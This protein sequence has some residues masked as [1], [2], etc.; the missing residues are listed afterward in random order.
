MRFRLFMVLALAPLVGCLRPGLEVRQEL[1]LYELSGARLLKCEVV[2]GPQGAQEGRGGRR[3]ERS[4]SR[5]QLR[6]VGPDGERFQGEWM[7]VRQ[8]QKQTT[9]ESSDDMSS[10][11]G[12]GL[13]VTGSSWDWASAMGVDMEKDTN[14]CI[15]LLY[16]DRGTVI[17]GIVVGDSG[18]GGGLMGAAKDN[19]GRRYRVMG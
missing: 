11:P 8:T 13:G 7:R 10:L 4:S 6:C 3:G 5:G 14:R 12:I 18:D 19:K 15:F 1:R 9:T 17:D 2:Q 16:G